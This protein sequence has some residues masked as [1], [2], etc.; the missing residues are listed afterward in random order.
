MTS[1]SVLLI[2]YPFISDVSFLYG[3]KGLEELSNEESVWY[4]EEVL[5]TLWVVAVA[6]A[7]D[8]LHLL[9]LA[10]LARRLDVLEVHVLLLAEVHDRAQEVEQACTQHNTHL[11]YTHTI[12]MYLTCTSCSWEKFTM[13]PRK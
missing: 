2:L 3:N 4:L 11:Q 5:D 6:L 13:E 1:C 7:A 8:A 10:R 12:W 9:D